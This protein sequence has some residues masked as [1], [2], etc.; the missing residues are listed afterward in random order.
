MTKKD[1]KTNHGKVVVENAV[2][3]DKSSV[4]FKCLCKVKKSLNL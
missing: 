4:K 2:T 3:W 1:I